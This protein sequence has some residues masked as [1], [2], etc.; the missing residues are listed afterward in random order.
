MASI[1]HVN[2]LVGDLWAPA[3]DSPV[4]VVQIVHGMT[5]HLGRYERFALQLAR[6]GYAAVGV[7]HLGH[8]RTCPDPEKR[9]VYQ[10]ENGASFMI[11]DQHRL[12]RMM[13]ER[14]PGLP[15]FFLGHSMGSFITRC[16][17]ARHGQGLTGAVILGTGWQNPLVLQVGIA[18]AKS[19]CLLRGKYYR[20][21]FIDM[22]GTGGYNRYFK[23]EPTHTGN[24]WLSRDPGIDELYLEDDMCGWEFS[25]SGYYSLFKLIEESQ[26][27]ARIEQIPKDLPVLIMSG[28]DDPVGDFGKAPQT[29]A[30]VLREA[31]M[32]DVSLELRELDRHELL[33]EL[34]HEQVEA[35]I[36][37]WLDKER[38]E[39]AAQADEAK[40]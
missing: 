5:E 33:N 7:D 20:S 26:D 37:N 28:T 10:P 1:D 25:V 13:Q 19:L 24:E 32:H 3:S 30:S 6:R 36:C 9:G 34:D 17:I 31:G 23:D 27:P 8:G 2:T 15:Y 18:L 22:L 14:Y 11:E 40:E 21:D 39:A 4:G 12:R 16:Y 35:L 29:L 38:G